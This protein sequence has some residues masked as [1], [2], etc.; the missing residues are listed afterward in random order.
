[1]TFEKALDVSF[2]CPTCGKLVNLVKNDKL[3][4]ALQYKIDQL[5]DDLKH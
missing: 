2:K 1:L 4:K 3:K 5:R